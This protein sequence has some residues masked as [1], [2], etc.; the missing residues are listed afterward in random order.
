VAEASDDYGGPYREALTNVCAELQCPSSPLFVLSPNGQ[1]GLGAHRNSYTVRPSA[2]ADEAMQHFFFL[3]KLIGC[4]LLEREAPLD[5]ELCPHVWKRLARVEPSAVDVADFDEG[6]Y[7]SLL[8]LR[9]IEQE[10]VDADL[11]EDIFFNTFEVVLSDGRLLELMPGGSSTDVTFASRGRYVDL[12]LA[13]RL[14]EGKAQC[15]E[16]LAGIAT[17][18]PSAR[19]LSLLTGHQLQLLTCGEADVDVEVLRA[20]TRYGAGVTPK[21]RHVRYL[22]QSLGGFTKE[23]RRAFLKFMWGRTRLPLTDQAWGDTKMR[24]HTLDTRSPDTHFPVAH[25]CF[26]SIEWPQYSSLKIAREKLLY[27]INNCS[28]IDADNT[29]EGRANASRNAFS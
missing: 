23:Q 10:G 29:R 5:L 1:H 8:K 3:G 16:M 24:I 7:G 6:A 17:M 15:D 12:A 20:H 2:S 18:L 27:A 25:T 26:F 19:L 22:W 11:F 13:A 28:A 21:Q 9:H 4:A 14:A